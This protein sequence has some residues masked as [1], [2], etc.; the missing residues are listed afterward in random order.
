MLFLRR[1]T[2]AAIYAFLAAQARFDF[3]Y[4]PTGATLACPPPGYDVDHTRVDLGRGESTFVAAKAALE[5][6]DQFRLSWLEAAPADT[7]LQVGQVVAVLARSFGLWWLNACRIVAVINDDGGVKRF[8]FGY[9]TLPGHMESGEERFQ[10]EWDQSND[11]VWYDILA[12]SRP[13][14]LLARVGY[15]MMRRLQKRFARESAAAMRRAVE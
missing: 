8:G 13:R 5:R 14:H 2:A 10:V 7:P 11:S 12:F 9:G 15:P 6:W 4:Q 3:T 1:P